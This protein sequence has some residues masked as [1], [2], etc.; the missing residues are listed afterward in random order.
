ML[1]NYDQTWHEAGAEK[2]HPI[3]MC[4]RSLHLSR[5][6]CKQ[7]RRMGGEINSDSY[8]SSLVAHVVGVLHVSTFVIE[9]YSLLSIAFKKQE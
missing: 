1:E 3:S 8:F 4:R 9:Y 2:S 7:R 6:S 5:E